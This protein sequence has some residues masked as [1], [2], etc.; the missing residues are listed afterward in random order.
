MYKRLFLSVNITLTLCLTSVLGNDL[1]I[2]TYEQRFL[3]NFPEEPENCLE[4]DVVDIDSINNSELKELVNDIT[5]YHFEYLVNEYDIVPLMGPDGEYRAFL[6]IFSVNSER[7][8]TYNAIFNYFNLMY[9][10]DELM[11]NSETHE[12]R[13]YYSNISGNYFKICNTYVGLIFGIVGGDLK[14][15]GITRYIPYVYSLKHFEENNMKF[16]ELLLLPSIYYNY[17]DSSYNYKIRILYE[18]NN[19]KMIEKM[20]YDSIRDELWLKYSNNNW[21]NWNLKSFRETLFGISTSNNNTVDVY[22]VF[23]N[24]ENHLLL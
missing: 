15:L 9:K 19:N 24:I 2:T 10:Y 13:D 18:V 12:D 7:E 5:L 8:S 4:F 14:P 23:M 3:D 16:V 6:V 20:S 21:K 11:W 22:A 17:A 1:E